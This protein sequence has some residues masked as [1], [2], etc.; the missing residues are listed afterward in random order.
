MPNFLSLPN[1]Q[2]NRITPSAP[3]EIFKGKE[4]P[5]AGETAQPKREA[6][7]SQEKPSTVLIPYPGQGGEGTVGCELDRMRRGD[8]LVSEMLSAGLPFTDVSLSEEP[9]HPLPGSA[10]PSP[11]RGDT[12]QHRSHLP[13]AAAKCVLNKGRLKPSG[14]LEAIFQ[15]LLGSS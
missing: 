15:H 3:T 7:H 14:I 4:H 12:N 13:L 10:V 11:W 1:G 9:S 2:Y 6:L 5:G 8:T